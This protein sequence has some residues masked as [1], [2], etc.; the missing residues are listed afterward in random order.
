MVPVP[1]EILLHARRGID[2]L[3]GVK[4]VEDLVW[5]PEAG[6]FA[7]RFEVVRESDAPHLPRQ[8]SWYAVLEPSYPIGS[9]LMV[10][11]KEGG[12][13]VTFQ[14]Q[15][16]NSIGNP[17]LPWR[18]GDVCV[19]VYADSVRLAGWSEPRDRT[20]LRWRVER[21]LDWLALAAQGQLAV[22]GDP[23]ELPQYPVWQRSP[24]AYSEDPDSFLLWSAIPNRVGLVSLG[25]LGSALAVRRF[26]D[27][28]NRELFRPKWGQAVR[29]SLESEVGA[30]IMLDGPLLC[31]PWHG[32]GTWAELKMALGDKWSVFQQA[33]DLV[34]EQRSPT[35]LFGMPMPEA[36][37]Q[38][39]TQIHWQALRL[40]EVT[41]KTNTPGFR[42]SKKNLR[43]LDN[44]RV[45]HDDLPLKWIPSENWAR[46]QLSRRRVSG[47]ALSD[48]H[49]LLVGCGAIG[50]CMG[51][52]MVRSG[53][54]KLLLCDGDVVTGG[55]LIRS[56]FNMQQVGENKA[57]ALKKTLQFL[58]PFAEVRAVEKSISSSFDEAPFGPVDMVLNCS[59]NWEVLHSL[60]EA[61]LN[62]NAVVVTVFVG[63]QARTLYFHAMRLGDLD[64]ATTI[65]DLQAL[66]DSEEPQVADSIQS[67]GIGCYHP[68]FPADVSRLWLHACRAMEVI[69]EK[70]PDAIL[71][72][73]LA[74]RVE[75]GAST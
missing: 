72:L 23:F 73:Q 33:V 67:E 70:L 27:V 39:Q 59:A 28:A 36:V 51:E 37:G 43:T 13:K 50:S 30:W 57:R 22:P 56:N 19:A 24:F 58:V 60:K 8:T 34:R 42:S 26:S 2:G 53:V 5:F 17:N 29:I 75:F 48:K 25:N 71:P 47:F 7:I 55:V 74:E 45:F 54:A 66:M 52:L 32:P 14:H 38:Q 15:S 6:R 3:P 4:I 10:P 65:R 12:L 62:Q 64:P 68:A 31:E 41:P 1:S 61:R 44:I 69:Q 35:V 9:V 16:N 40:P 46:S 63:Y 18:N 11:A 49:V 20:R 21:L